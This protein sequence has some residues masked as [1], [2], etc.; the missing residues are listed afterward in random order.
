MCGQ[1]NGWWEWT[2]TLSKTATE[3]KL[4]SAMAYN[5]QSSATKSV[6]FGSFMITL[7]LKQ[8]ATFPVMI[9]ICNAYSLGKERNDCISTRDYHQHFTFTVGFSKTFKNHLT[10]QCYS[11]LWRSI[12]TNAAAVCKWLFWKFCYTSEIPTLFSAEVSQHNHCPA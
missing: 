11:A 4:I 2:H 3:R 12:K 10:L 5:G 8:L 6:P 9:R 1:R 7:V